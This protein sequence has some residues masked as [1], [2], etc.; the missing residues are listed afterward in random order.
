MYHEERMQV[1]DLKKVIYSRLDL[2][3][4]VF[5]LLITYGVWQIATKR[6][7]TAQNSL[8]G[9]SVTLKHEI[10]AAN[11]AIFQ[12][13]NGVRGLYV[14]SVQVDSDVLSNYVETT[15]VGDQ[16]SPLLRLGYVQRVSPDEEKSFEKQVRSEGN[17]E[18]K[19]APNQAYESQFYVAKTVD[20]TGKIYIPSGRNL[21]FDP[22]YAETIKKIIETKKGQIIYVP[23]IQNVDEY[24]GPSFIASLPVYKKGV[25]Q[26]M[27]NGVISVEEM[28][29][30]IG[31]MIGEGVAWRWSITD[32]TVLGEGGSVQG[33]TIKEVVEIAMFDEISW[34]IELEKEIVPSQLLNSILGLGVLISF[35]LYTTVYSLSTANVK[36]QELARRMTVD[37]EK[38]KLALDSARNHIIITDIDGKILYANKSVE[39]LTGY[40]AEEVIG[41]NPRLWGGRMPEEF[42]GKLWKTIKVDKKVFEGEINNKRKNGELYIAQTTISPIIDNVS[43]ELVGFVGIEED[44]TDRKRGEDETKKMNELMVGREL[45][46][47]ELKK[48]I[49]RLKK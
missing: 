20:K 31:E 14:S 48:E 6:D 44:I 46:M 37:L 39:I 29:Q 13:I 32:G 38:Y 22:R 24:G 5:C 19:A 49:E 2:I 11:E 3:V 21:F 18:Y 27:I 43:S 33:A 12:E 42:Y 1:K 16:L 41:Q 34:Q 26:G 25:L 10:E 7:T 4:L 8:K 17:I 9:L 47:V 30:K 45:K 36:G 23:S 28:R 35:M 15:A 40:S